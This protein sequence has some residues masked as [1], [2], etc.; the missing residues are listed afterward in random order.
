MIQQK[1]VPKIYSNFLLTFSRISCIVYLH[2]TN[3]RLNKSYK[4]GIIK[5]TTWQDKTDSKQVYQEA[6]H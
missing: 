6:E 3:E 5:E 2:R 4:L 1:Y